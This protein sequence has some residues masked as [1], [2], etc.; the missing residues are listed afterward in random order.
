[1]LHLGKWKTFM[2][3][4]IVYTVEEFA[5]IMKMNPRTIRNAIK[6]NK[7]RA[8]RYKQNKRSPYRIPYSEIEHFQVSLMQETQPDLYFVED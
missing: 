5:K 8:F 2:D 6:E 4:E 7:L 1:M 3:K